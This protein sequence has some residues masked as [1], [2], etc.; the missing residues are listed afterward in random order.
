[1]HGQ[2]NKIR[3]MCLFKSLSCVVHLY[4]QEA[5]SVHNDSNS[6]QWFKFH[7]LYSYVA[8]LHYVVTI[9][10]YHTAIN[11]SGGLQI[12]LGNSDFTI[13]S[14]LF[15]STNLLM[16]NGGHINLISH[17][18]QSFNSTVYLSHYTSKILCTQGHNSYFSL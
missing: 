18:F 8:Y 1:M 7:Y 9:S 11:S 4:L 2:Q 17:Y 15:L 6:F 12:M 5:I 14:V 13:L 3:E 16:P 10:V